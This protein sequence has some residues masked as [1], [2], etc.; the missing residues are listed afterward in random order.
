[1]ICLFNDYDLPLPCKSFI[2]MTLLGQEK[3]VLSSNTG[4]CPLVNYSDGSYPFSNFKPQDINRR[5]MESCVSYSIHILFA[6]CTLYFTFLWCVKWFSFHL[7]RMAAV[8]CGY[9]LKQ[10]EKKKKATISVFPIP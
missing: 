6:E 4:L 10:L 2:T 7:N 9:T 1:M 3:R 5:H 8:V